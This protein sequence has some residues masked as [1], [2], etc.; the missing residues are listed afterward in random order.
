MTTESQQTSAGGGVGLLLTSGA[1]ALALLLVVV[2]VAAVVSGSAAAAGSLAGGV[3]ALVVFLAGSLVV[4]SVAGLAPALSLVFALS[5]Y[6]LQLL[7]LGS[8]FSILG[9]SDLLGASLDAGWLGATIIAVTVAWL[10]VQVVL[11]SRARIPVYDLT[12][13]RRHGSRHDVLSRAGER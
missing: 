2:G 7:V 3:M 9:R 8:F 4:N 13:D 12:H 10:A 11:T 1:A 5:T 6:A